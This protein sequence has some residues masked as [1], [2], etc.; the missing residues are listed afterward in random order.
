[1]ESAGFMG[2]HATLERA[3][4]AGASFLTPQVFGGSAVAAGLGLLVGLWVCP[5]LTSKA[6]PWTPAINLP[7]EDTTWQTQTAPSPQWPPSATTTLPA[8]QAGWASDP[9]VNSTVAV[10]AEVVPARTVPVS[11]AQ[12]DTPDNL[13]SAADDR[14]PGPRARDGDNWPSSRGDILAGQDSRAPDRTHGDEPRGG[15]EPPPP[16]PPDDP[17]SPMP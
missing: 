16:G 5:P 13:R 17:S 9:A 1:M 10:S 3:R 7:Q 12:A 11:Y 15:Y 6:E 14:D 2:G 4:A 8:T